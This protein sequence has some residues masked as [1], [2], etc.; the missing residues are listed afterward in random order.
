MDR[1]GPKVPATNAFDHLPDAKP[2]GAAA[3]GRTVGQQVTKEIAD[4]P[5]DLAK[6]TWEQVH[7]GLDL[8]NDSMKRSQSGKVGAM[9]AGPE[10]ALGTAQIVASPVVG[11]FETSLGKPFRRMMPD[12]DLG[13]AV[14]NTVDQAVLIFGPESLGTTASAI[15]NASTPVRRLLESGVQLMPGQLNPMFGKRMEEAAKSLP[16][17]GSFIRKAEQRTKDSFNVAT[18]NR[19]LGALG[20]RVEATNGREAMTK[21][22]DIA[23]AKYAEIRAGIPALHK[24]SIYDADIQRLRMKM[25]EFSDEDRRRIEAVLKN[26]VTSK[27]D[28]GMDVMNGEKFKEAESQ[29]TRIAN[30]FRGHPAHINYVKGVDGIRD[31]LRD[32]VEQQYPKLAPKLKEIN[33]LYARLADID[34]AQQRRSGSEGSFTP[35][36]LLASLKRSD[37][38]PRHVQFNEGNR[39]MQE[40]A[41][42]ANKVI[43]SKMSDSGTA[44]RIGFGALEGSLTGGS[45]LEHHPELLVGT[46]GA[47]A[48]YSKTGQKLVNK[49][50]RASPD[51]ARLTGKAAVRAAPI[52]EAASQME[53]Q[54]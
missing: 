46:A 34:Y 18:V 19:E 14:A 8:I 25:D 7:G 11:G 24:S 43:S 49:A 47:A 29:L 42:D 51:V 28:A 40:W 3:G 12:N 27:W 22:H 53:N 2:P 17:V 39:P 50:A 35:M 30:E 1:G 10:A 38:S 32:A 44:E 5:V 23:D 31:A 15:K 45:A 13:R 4:L 52:G 21:A 26:H 16:L 54:P 33:N 9:L 36:D 20:E 48:L 6:N 41:E 37:K